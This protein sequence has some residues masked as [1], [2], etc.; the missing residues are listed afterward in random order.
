MPSLSAPS[1][2]NTKSNNKRLSLKESERLA[3]LKAAEKRAPKAKVKLEELAMF[4]QQLSS[5]LLAG[6][7]LVS[8]MDALQEQVPS[9]VFQV[10]L[11]NVRSDVASGTPFSEA[12][13]KYP[14]AFPKLF[15]SMTQAGE[16]SGNLGDILAKTAA[17]FSETVKLTKKVK[18]AM[19]YPIT[20]ILFAI[21]LVNVL[22]IFVIPVFGEMFTSFGKELPTLTQLLLD[23]SE[24]MKSYIVYILF[25][26]A[27]SSKFLSVFFATPKGRIVKDSL[28]L[29]APIFGE[30]SRKINLSRFCRTFSILLK[31]GVP[32]LR[33]LE[34]VAMGS[35]NT[36]IEK[37][38]V[39]ISRH[40]SQGGQISEILAVTPYFPSL[41]K[42][43]VQA[44]EQTGDIDSMLVKVSDFYDV[45]IENT[46]A[47]L[48]SLLEPILIVFLGAVIG[49]IV[50]AM[51][52][53]IFQL[54][55]VVSG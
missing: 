4:T 43:M 3:K 7:P 53:P 27:I 40:I 50:M 29:K 45:E 36:F 6:L 21:A 10:I 9:L 12:C 44:G 20:V 54:A 33:S 11:R 19:T 23:L 55:T 8:A 47:A 30:L 38:S 24:F 32:I 15:T 16:A 48:T 49:T 18:S 14:K 31:S 28:V 34:I 1:K 5:M 17:Y 42:H 2:Y 35:N 25:V 37:A 51:F 22:L 26:I 39:D 46:V 52:L 13:E 41:I